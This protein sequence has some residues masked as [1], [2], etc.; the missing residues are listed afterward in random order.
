MGGGG[1][2]RNR[3]FS[4]SAKV[5]CLTLPQEPLFQPLAS[6]QESSGDEI[7]EPTPTEENTSRTRT[8]RLSSRTYHQQET[9]ER[10]ASGT[11]LEQ[12]SAGRPSLLTVTTVRGEEEKDEGEKTVVHIPESE[13]LSYSPLLPAAPDDGAQPSQVQGAETKEQSEG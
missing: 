2:S 8:R 11:L 6:S 5:Y 12:E 9:G 13:E 3:A 4:I 1:S 7:I 10:P